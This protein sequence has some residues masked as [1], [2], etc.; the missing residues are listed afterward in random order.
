MNGETDSGH[1]DLY[2]SDEEAA[3]MF[4]ATQGT[5]PPTSPAMK[6]SITTVKVLPLVACKKTCEDDGK[7][8][9]RLYGVSFHAVRFATRCCLCLFPVT[10]M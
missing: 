3:I 2:D 4:S 9:V 1:V 7:E 5:Q 6:M 8:M 10:E